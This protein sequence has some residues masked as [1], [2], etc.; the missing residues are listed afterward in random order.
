MEIKD[1]LTPVVSSAFYADNFDYGLLGNQ[2]FYPLKNSSLDDTVQVVLI[3]LNNTS[4]SLKKGHSFSSDTLRSYLYCLAGFQNLKINDLGDFISGKTMADNYAGIEELTIYL[5]NKKVIPIFFGGSQEMSLAISKGIFKAQQKI[6]ATFIDA[7]IDYSN[8]EDFHSQS[9]LS[10]GFYKSDTLKIKTILGYQAYLASNQKLKVLKD[11]GFNLYR[12]GSIRNNFQAI[13]PILRDTHFCSF[14]MSA[15][16]YSDAPAASF[17]SPNGLYAEEACQLA[18]IA[19][20]SDNLKA[21]Y[22]G[23]LD[24][25][26]DQSGQSTHLLAQVIW[27]FLSGLSARKGDY[28][29][30][31]ID[32]YKKIYITNN[33]T[34]HELL[35]YQNKENNRFWIK[36][37]GDNHEIIACSEQDYKA[38]CFNEIPE[39]I[40]KRISNT[41]K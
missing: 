21:V 23:E 32:N 41:L 17:N 14:D 37:P 29:V 12:L 15:V 39:R 33:K 10:D 31:S 16:R 8:D 36:L 40:W 4:N 34:G 7:L 28:P 38:V 3:G 35:F 18:N 1:Y 11:Q 22:V 30:K 5:V 26:Q 9:Y 24:T 20:L 2:L 19:G 6:E 13:E 25:V 27:H